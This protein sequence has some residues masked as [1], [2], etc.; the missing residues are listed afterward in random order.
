M[1]NG[2][3]FNALCSE[4]YQARKLFGCSTEFTD[5]FDRRCKKIGD[6]LKE[7]QGVTDCKKVKF[8][9]TTVFGK[10]AEAAFLELKEWVN[11]QEK[12]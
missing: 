12:E 9:G 5:E 10:K 11:K 1:V 3:D 4:V 7:E 8:S 6:A 2:S